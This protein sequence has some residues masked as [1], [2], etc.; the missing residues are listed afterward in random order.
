MLP[1]PQ[2]FS[3]YSY[4]ASEYSRAEVLERQARAAAKA[5]QVADSEFVVR[6]P[7]SGLTRQLPQFSSYTYEP[8]PF[9]VS[10]RRWSVPLSSQQH[11]P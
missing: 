6:A 11:H 1:P 9:E 5:S 8:T 2:A 7:P 3:R 4:M 10:R